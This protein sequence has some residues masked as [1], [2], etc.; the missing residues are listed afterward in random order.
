MLLFFLRFHPRG[1]ALSLSILS[2]QILDRHWVALS[3]CFLLSLFIFSR[4]YPLAATLVLF[5]AGDPVFLV[6]QTLAKHH[7]PQVIHLSLLYKLQPR[8]ASDY[9]LQRSILRNFP[10]GFLSFY[11][12]LSFALQRLFSPAR[13]LSK[14]PVPQELTITFKSFRLPTVSLIFRLSSKDSRSAFQYSHQLCRLLF[15]GYRII[16]ISHIKITQHKRSPFANVCARFRQ[17]QQFTC[18]EVDIISSERSTSIFLSFPPLP[19]IKEK[20]R[21]R[22]K[23]RKHKPAEYCAMRFLFISIFTL[24][25]LTK[26]PIYNPLLLIKERYNPQD[27]PKSLSCENAFSAPVVIL[28][29]N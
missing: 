27:L 21:K 20:E 22:E 24:A 3:V 1:S 19:R 25:L 15:I 8:L 18:G 9:Q 14:A 23:V 4:P 11:I 2:A 28:F 29:P 6:S 7:S 16:H 13:L 5:S 26:L 10:R 17:F 12:L